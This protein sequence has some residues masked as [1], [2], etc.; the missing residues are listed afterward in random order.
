[1]I[2]TPQD[3]NILSNIEVRCRYRRLH[4]SA[5]FRGERVIRVS[6]IGCL[7]GRLQFVRHIRAYPSPVIA[8]IR[9]L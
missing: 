1:M 5:G 7:G 9:L 3:L 8:E 4:N 6:L 2:L